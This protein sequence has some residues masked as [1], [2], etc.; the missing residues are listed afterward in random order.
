MLVHTLGNCTVSE[1]VTRVEQATLANKFGVV[2][3]F[4]LQNTI[5]VKAN[6]DLSHGW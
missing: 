6:L 4:D 1:A 2:G 3:K 5:K